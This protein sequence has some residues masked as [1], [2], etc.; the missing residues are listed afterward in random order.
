MQSRG[1]EILREI[2]DA[3][4]NNATSREFLAE[5]INRLAGFYEDHG[6]PA[7]ALDYFRQSHAL[8][9]SL[10]SA[11]PQNSLAKVN[12][13]FSE[14]G[15]GRSLLDSGKSESANKAFHKAAKTFEGLASA[16]SKNRYVRTG[17][18]DSYFGLGKTYEAW[19]SQPKRSP[20]KKRESWLEARSWFQKS[21]AVWADKE[22]LGEIEISE[23]E[24]VA[25]VAQ[26][27]AQCEAKLERASVHRASE[28][29]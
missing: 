28:F 19:A 1:V 18:A 26:G 27:L 11:D 14:N 8:F 15:I 22:R 23:R 3:H 29:R 13:G 2:S 21:S 9:E 12:F 20:V 10:V 16:T 4:P 7:I 25:K 24:D 6:A 17:L 5:A